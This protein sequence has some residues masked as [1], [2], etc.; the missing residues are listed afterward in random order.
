MLECTQFI[1]CLS[2]EGDCRLHIPVQVETHAYNDRRDVIPLMYIML[3]F[4]ILEGF[5]DWGFSEIKP[6][7]AVRSM[8]GLLLFS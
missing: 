4:F 3:Y 2:N 1:V 7:V 8:I 5:L 6:V